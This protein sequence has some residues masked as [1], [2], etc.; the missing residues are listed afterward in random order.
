M[1][2]ESRSKKSVSEDYHEIFNGSFQAEGPR[3][4]RPKKSII[5]E[6]E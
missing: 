4:A 3:T 1:T 5:V 2:K 6:E